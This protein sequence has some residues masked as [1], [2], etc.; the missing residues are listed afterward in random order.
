MDPADVHI[1]KLASAF[2]TGE[3]YNS[4]IAVKRVHDGIEGILQKAHG[5]NIDKI[6]FIGGNDILHV[7]DQPPQPRDVSKY[8]GYVVRKFLMAKKLLYVT[9]WASR[10]YSDV[11][12]YNPAAWLHERFYAFGLYSIM[13]RK[14]KQITF[15][16]SATAGFIYGKNLIGTTRRRGQNYYL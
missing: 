5:F 16:C 11:F 2:E 10:F 8:F 3:D 12:C 4:Q 13:V 1:G 6:L 15:D 7:D 14:C 9:Y